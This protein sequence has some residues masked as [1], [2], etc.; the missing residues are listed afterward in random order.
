MIFWVF[1]WFIIVICVTTLNKTLFTALHCPYPV[2]ITMIHMLSCFIYS[3][4]MKCVAPGMF[5]YRPLRRNEWKTMF[6][7]SLIFIINIIL[8]NSSIKYNSLALDQMFRCSM[9]VFTCV[10]E[11]LIQGTV[12]PFGVYLSLIPVIIGTMLVCAGDVDGTV[13]GVVLLFISCT[14]SSLKGIV[15]KYLLSGK[16]PLSTFQLLNINSMF[17]FFE[18][19]F[20]SL[21]KDNQF[22]VSWLPSAPMYSILLLV[23]HGMLAFLLNIA[24]FNAVKEGGP[25]MMNVVGNVKQVTI[26]I[27]SV[28]LFKNKM[29]PIGI[30]G[31]IICISGSMWYTYEN[32]R[33]RK[34]EKEE[35]ASDG[36]NE[37][38]LN[39]STRI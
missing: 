5:H 39:N 13:W 38:L 23:F 2:T 3:S 36:E 11:Y 14:I 15:T 12:R 37:S 10:L 34:N 17:S 21:F 22:W 20:L 28:F 25:L 33:Y 4:I 35:K 9:P 31:S 29:K 26:I 18:I 7:V 8:S 30:L 16:E 6:L 27:L 19:I 1:A 24:N 32:S